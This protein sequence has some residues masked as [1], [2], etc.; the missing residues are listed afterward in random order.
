MIR[1]VRCKLC[2][3]PAFFASFLAKRV[4]NLIIRIYIVKQYVMDISRK[5]AFMKHKRL[6]FTLIF[7]LFISVFSFHAYAEYNY[8]TVYTD[9]PEIAERIVYG[10]S[11]AGRDLVAYRFGTG[12]NVMVVGFGIHGYEDNFSR[13]GLALVYTADL[14]MD[15]LEENLNTVTDYDWSIYV[16][17]CMNPDGLLDGWTCNGPG[18]CTTTYLDSTGSL[19]TTEKKGVDLNRSFPYGWTKRTDARNFN[20]TQPLAAQEA[21]ALADFIEDVK[22]T[23]QN[24]CIDAHG[25]LSQIITSNGSSSQLY[26]IF[27]NAFPSNT[28]A[29]CMNG[30]GYF[31]AYAGSIGYMSC[32]FE[33]PN[34]TSLSGFQS[35]G[36]PEKFNDCILKLATAYGTYRPPEP[37][38]EDV[39][40]TRNYQDISA[41]GWYHEAT[42]FCLYNGLIL[43]TS[44]TENIFSPDVSLTRGMVV[45]VLHRISGDTEEYTTQFPDVPEDAW[46]TGDVGWAQHYDIVAGCG[47]GLFHPDDDVSRQDMVSILYRYAKK[48]GYDTTQTANLSAF[49]DADQIM[50]YAKPC[51]SWAYATGI[52]HGAQEGNDIFLN[53]LSGATRVEAAQLLMTF[54]HEILGMDTEIPL[55]ST[56][57]QAVAIDLTEETEAFTPPDGTDLDGN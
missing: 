34:T 11:G 12:E 20:G 33:F 17:P 21:Q 53:P 26:K 38:H 49:P 54:C 30:S 52:L 1:R 3:E 6:C 24:I 48:C 16:L 44:E 45:A 7:C 10:T 40:P 13:D 15:L 57:T 9:V 42:D 19:V 28:Y 18:R 14:L 39:C 55:N 22:G 37:T 27:K 43:G 51:M 50:D 25:W 41:D 36:Y 31:T 8:G 47:D 29:N 32:L 46:Y 5:E 4:D 56:Q 35:S 23:G 2:N